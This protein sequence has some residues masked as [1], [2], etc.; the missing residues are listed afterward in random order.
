MDGL[1]CV[2]IFGN[3]KKLLY[4]IPFTPELNLFI[5]MLKFLW[6]YAD[7]IMSE[8]KLKENLFDGTEK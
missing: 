2:M 1:R 7:R 3:K 8:V 6:K 4:Y 5:K